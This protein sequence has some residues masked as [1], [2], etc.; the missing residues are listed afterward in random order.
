MKMK[1]R[2]MLQL[3]VNEVANKFAG[4]HF[5]R[6]VRENIVRHLTSAIIDYVQVT[7]SFLKKSVENSRTGSFSTIKK[8]RY[9]LDMELGIFTGLWISH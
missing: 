7:V 1:A 3:V 4:S 8:T 5:Q 2:Y 6:G 9:I